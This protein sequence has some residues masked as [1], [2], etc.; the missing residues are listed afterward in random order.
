MSPS[1]GLPAVNF[2]MADVGGGLGAFLST[3]LAE[4]EHWDAREI[5]FILSAGL[6]TGMLLSTPAGSI[7][8]RLGH[9][10]VML[11]GTCVSV[12]TGTL[13]LFVVSGFWPVLAAQILVAAGWRAGHAGAD[14]ADFG[15]HRQG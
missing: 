9:P 10:R 15:H 1:I 5:G 4:T 7:I 2:F 6:L 8:D 13:A 14:G 3:W 12:V 11:V